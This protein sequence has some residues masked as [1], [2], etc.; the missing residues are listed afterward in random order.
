MDVWL[1]QGKLS[2]KTYGR[3][4]HPLCNTMW[5]A[6]AGIEP[7]VVHGETDD[8]GYNA[9]EN[10]V[11]VRDFHATM[12]HMLGIDHT[13]LTYK[14]QGLDFRLT[15]FEEARVVNELLG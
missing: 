1:C 7:G 12:L 9:V 8:F 5:F 11:H 10:R 3:D 14:F 4:H 6:G 15:G 13:R 2:R